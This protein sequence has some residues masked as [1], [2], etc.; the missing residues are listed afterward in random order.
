MPDLEQHWWQRDEV[1]VHEGVL[2]TVHAIL[3]NQKY[4]EH[5]FA[6]SLKLYGNA[7][8]YG[9]HG[10]DYARVKRASKEKRL[11]LNVVK[12]MA[13][14]TTAKMG[15]KKPRAQF[16][17]EGGDWSLQQKARKLTQFVDG[18]FYQEKCYKKGRICFKDGSLFGKGLA[19]VFSS[20]GKICVER[21]FPPEIIVDDE[22]ARLA[23]PRTLFQRKFISRH[24]LL[25]MYSDDPQAH[26]MIKNAHP[27]TSHQG[28]LRR[29]SRGRSQADMLEV[30]EAW[31]KP[32]TPDADDGKHAIV[33][34]GYTLLFEDWDG[35]EFPFAEFD[36]DEPVLG[37]WPMGLAEELVPIQRE[38]NIII[39]RM[40]EYLR[41]V[42]VPRVYVDSASEIVKA[43]INNIIGAVVR[44]N[45]AGGNPPVFETPSV[46]PRDMFETLLMLFEKAY[47]IA[48]VS[49][50]S[51]QAKKPSG[52][53]SGKALRTF[54]DIETERFANRQ[55]SYQEFYLQ[56][57]K[58]IIQ[59]AR[60]LYRT[61]SEDESV[62]VEVKA[63]KGRKFV[64][65][66]KWSEI[67]LEDDMFVMQAFPVNFLPKTPA[68]RLQFVQELMS[69]GLI[70]P[71]MGMSL[72]DFPDLEAYQSLVNAP[73]EDIKAMI[74]DMLDGQY[75]PPEPFQ[76]LQ[77]G[78]K[79]VTSA[80]LKAKRD[81]APEDVLE[82][83]LRW[84]EDAHQMLKETQAA[85]AAGPAAL[86]PGAP[87]NGAGPQPQ[88]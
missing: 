62:D 69:S 20:G 82:L 72:L 4:R 60:N 71:Q 78:I 2:S 84:T 48:G 14:T 6:R 24:V 17:T 30:I 23:P 18:V 22:E 74:E 63:V 25:E 37:W 49:E 56:L 10:R 54:D 58:L 87:P 15:T 5:N 80:R 44:Y 40:V 81:N 61:D 45:S 73:L 88:P 29:A 13:D 68:A 11:A 12:S 77:L 38:I 47:Q 43:H 66:I 67:D 7:D 36:W 16:L 33:I 8:I 26:Q 75:F 32:S 31:H 27:A 41:R 35:P 85:M 70:D 3:N 86:P 76:N 55:Q 9:L 46:I 52:L 21:V 83:M 59:E 34:D 50:M 1:S 57:A 64:R 79:L 19:K 65:S 39:R 42:A 28:Q 51:A 53:N